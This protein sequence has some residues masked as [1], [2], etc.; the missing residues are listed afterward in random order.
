MKKKMTKRIISL[1]IALVMI[2]TMFATAFVSEAEVMSKVSSFTSYTNSLTLDYGDK[3]TG[4][5]Y[6]DVRDQDAPFELYGLYD[7]YNTEKFIRM[8]LSKASGAGYDSSNTGVGGNIKMHAQ[9][10]SGARVRF[11][12]DSRYVAIA[13]VIPNVANDGIG[14]YI[15]KVAG[16][17]YGTGYANAAFDLYEDKTE[18]SEY[19]DTFYPSEVLPKCTFNEITWGAIIDLGT[20]ENRDLTIYFPILNELKDLYIGF[21][22]DA[23]IGKNSVRFAN[24]KDGVAAPMVWLGSSITQ[25]GQ[26]DRPGNTFAA[27][28]ARRFNMDFI[29]LGMWGSCNSGALSYGLLDYIT[30]LPNIG[31]FISDYDHNESATATLKNSHWNVYTAVREKFPDIPYIMISRP[32]KALATWADM[33]DAIRQNYEKAIANGDTNVYF[34][35]GQSFFA[36]EDNYSACFSDG[37][38]HPSAYGAGLMAKGIGDVIENITSGFKETSVIYSTKFSSS[39]VSSDFNGSPVVAKGVMNLS[40]KNANYYLQES[41]SWTDQDYSVS[42]VFNFASTSPKSLA[43]LL[44]RS[45]DGNNG[46]EFMLWRADAAAEKLTLRLIKRVEGVA[47]TLGQTSAVYDMDVDHELKVMAKGGKVRCFIDGAEVFTDK[48]LAAP[49]ASGKVGIGALFNPDCTV[50]NFTVK[51]IDK[52]VEAPHTGRTQSLA[53]ESFHSVDDLTAIADGGTETTPTKTWFNY[54][55]NG[56]QYE[57]R[58]VGGVKKLQARSGAFYYNVADALGWRNYNVKVDMM[59]QI[60]NSATHGLDA[61]DSNDRAGIRVGITNINSAAGKSAQVYYDGATEKFYLAFY[62]GGT[63]KD[64]VTLSDDLG[65]KV[66]KTMTLEVE[67]VGAKLTAYIEDVNVG[68]YTFDSAIVGT[69]GVLQTSTNITTLFDNLSAYGEWPEVGPE[70]CTY[71]QGFGDYAIPNGWSST[72]STWSFADKTANFNNLTSKVAGTLPCNVSGASSWANKSYSVDMMFNTLPENSQDYFPG[73]TTFTG[74]WGFDIVD[75]VN[76]SIEVRLAYVTGTKK[77]QYRVGYRPGGSFT[78][79]VA[80]ADITDTAIT[81][82]LNGGEWVNVRVD[83]YGNSIFF[84]IDNVF[85]KSATTNSDISGS[86]TLRSQAGL[87]DYSYDNLLITDSAPRT[88]LSSTETKVTGKNVYF[89]AD[90]TVEKT[91]AA[92]TLPDKQVW[93]PFYIELK[94]TGNERMRIRFFIQKLDGK[95]KTD[96]DIPVWNTSNSATRFYLEQFTDF[97]FGK[98]HKFEFIRLGNYFEVKYDGKLAYQHTVDTVNGGSPTLVDCNSMAFAGMQASL[99]SFAN[100]LSYGTI[101]DAYTVTAGD[102]VSVADVYTDINKNTGSTPRDTYRAGETVKLT[103]ADNV[104]AGTLKYNDGTDHYIFNTGADKGKSNG[105]TFCFTMPA[106]NTTVSAELNATGTDF[107]SATLAASESLDGDAIRFLNRVYLPEQ[108]GYGF[109]TSV[110]YNGAACEITDIG[111]I[112]LPTELLDT[113]GVAG[114]LELD[115]VVAGGAKKASIVENPKLYDK[116]AEYVDFCISISGAKSGREYTVV[117]YVTLNDGTTV[118]GNEFSATFVGEK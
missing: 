8:D 71:F 78:A 21:S 46:L 24:E 109:S 28:I 26:V 39:D 44:A 14:S 72:G 13:A 102:N 107:S 1:A 34:I 99:C 104:K 51:Y 29:N 96:I 70:G 106:A 62:D 6:L 32:G 23:S 105:K 114:K 97:E 20:A 54:G 2:I 64:T 75:K 22:S 103:A 12:T 5:V 59:L 58:T 60:K 83:T 91:M 87:A 16:Q 77:W 50:D 31:M 90:I 42:A 56:L 79:L 82:K 89:S 35:D 110:N 95:Y 117:T 53:S 94:G 116:T 3:L 18:G 55:G 40:G 27:I 115:S 38:T 19:V 37:G 48:D 49:F 118:Y 36:N 57:M 9:E 98:S 45:Q 4:G 111:A 11:S 73:L 43:G 7:P 93:T 81:D 80:Q 69:F 88:A 92:S 15:D 41:A 74:Y 10:P 113:Y 30:S 108:S 63:L 85:V 76:S 47:T 101:D 84:Y 25:G 65:L 66:E 61:F 68:S 67:I 33:R 100:N 86:I 52:T 112:I 17:V